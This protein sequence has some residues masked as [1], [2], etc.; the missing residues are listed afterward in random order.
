M[1]TTFR[2]TYYGENTFNYN[3]LNLE[4]PKNFIKKFIKIK[5]YKEIMIDKCI[6]I[7]KERNQSNKKYNIISDYKMNSRIMSYENDDWINIIFNPLNYE[8]LLSNNGE[9]FVLI[10]LN[11]FT[12][13][14][15]IIIKYLHYQLHVIID[16]YYFIQGKIWI[17]FLASS[18]PKYSFIS[19]NRYSYYFLL[20]MNKLS[21]YLKYLYSIFQKYDYS[22]SKIKKDKEVQYLFKM[23]N[24]DTLFDD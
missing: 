3:S 13:D 11:N 23:F 16:P 8:K 24:I 6:R 18:L 9:Q 4:I 15:N 14:M 17:N 7:L 19:M 5:K 21:I 10:D 20:Y 12:H 22:I 1:I 2:F